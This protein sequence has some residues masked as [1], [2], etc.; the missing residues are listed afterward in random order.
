MY[1]IGLKILK[2]LENNGYEAYI[3]GGAARDKYLGIKSPDID[4]ATNARPFEI[5][6]VF[7]LVKLP[8]A[9]YG[10][11]S[12]YD[13]T[14]RFEITTFRREINYIDNRHPSTVEYIS[15]LKEDLLRRDFTINTLCIDSDGE[16]LDLLGAKADIDAKII[17]TLKDPVESFT[18]DVLRI[19]RAIR[20]ATTLYFDLTDD[21]RE[22]IIETKHLLK[23]ISYERKKDEL[24]KIFACPN[25]KYGLKLLRD[26]GLDEVLEINLDRIEILDD[27]LPMWYQ[28]GVSNIYPFSKREK[29]VFKNIDKFYNEDFEDDYILYKAGLY[30]G[31]TIYKLKGLSAKNLIN[32]FKDIPI[33]KNSDIV[34]N[35]NDICSLL[36]I[37]PTYLLKEILNDL[38]KKIVRKELDND[39]LELTNYILENYKGKRYEE[40]I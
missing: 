20:F 10:A 37:K 39:V 14:Y 2:E 6:K 28:L 36:N 18:A 11:V 38:E 25:K 7:P 29:D 15:N 12:V 8:S 4:I 40:E 22:A 26:L 35:A 13:K 34:V 1:K 24:N 32:R 9:K 27:P 31:S 19:L 33:L 3:V 5:K 16:L 21:T 23:N 30:I 17:K